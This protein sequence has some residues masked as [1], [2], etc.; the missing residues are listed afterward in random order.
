M[1]MH[2]SVVRRIE[3]LRRAMGAD[4]LAVGRDDGVM[5]F[6]AADLE[7]L[8][9]LPGV[10]SVAGAT[11]SG[12]ASGLGKPYALTYAEVTR[13]YLEAFGV[14]LALGPGFSAAPGPEA[15]L[16]AN[17]A[18]ALFPNQDPIGQIVDGLTVVGVITEIP[19]W[20]N[21]R[22]DLNGKILVPDG[23][24]PA[25]VY[26]ASGQYSPAI[27]RATGDAAAVRREIETRFPNWSIYDAGLAATI[28]NSV[29]LR[30]TRAS[31][32]AGLALVVLV[33][34]G[35]AASMTLTVLRRM[36]E[37][38]IRRAVGAGRG[39]IA[40]DVVAEAA[41]I[42]FAGG[43]VGTAVAAALSPVLGRLPVWM[44][45]A[46][47]TYGLAVGA[48][49]A[50]IPAL[51]ASRMRPVSALAERSLVASGGRR[52]NPSWWVT[53]AATC[54]AACGAGL[55]I[56][57]AVAI[58][59]EIDAAW[60]AADDRILVVGTEPLV[61]YLRGPSSVLP[62]AELRR[63]DARL[64][65]PLGEVDAVVCAMQSSVKLVT[66]MGKL[67]TWATFVDR[68]FAELRLLNILEGRGLNEDDIGSR[69]P[70]CL[71]GEATAR[72][73]WGNARDAIGG[74]ITILPQSAYR[75]VGVFE[76]EY[77]VDP[78]SRGL[79]A[80]VQ[81]DDRM[82]L[83]R[84]RFIVRMHDRRDV[85][86]ARSEIAAAFVGAYPHNAP[87]RV[88]PLMGE[89]ARILRSV[90]A[91]ARGVTPSLLA[92]V[93]VA[94]WVA[95]SVAGFRL[96]ART[97]EFGVR[98]ALGL[99]RF[100]AWHFG[101]REAITLTCI[102]AALGC[103]VAGLCERSV[104]QWVLQGAEA[105]T[106]PVTLFAVLAGALALAASLGVAVAWRMAVGPVADMLQKGRE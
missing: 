38:G 11:S 25:Y 51:T 75:V 81:P 13:D 95:L 89:N 15:I 3:D 66:Q 74:E 17:V 46:L 71:L 62:P 82:P 86:S 49:A 48:V 10:A 78:I 103:T 21:L 98:R 40:R 39:R 8:R 79:V 31:V 36:R 41:A 57:I 26:I 104:R 45:G 5:F 96:R 87:V 1:A 6:A 99:P 32:V 24:A 84:V 91:V 80:P 19:T 61:G 90:L 102:G 97:L 94:A 54:L 76:D 77:I 18:A 50:L 83:N 105:P 16:G 88:L 53:T 35:V 60:G 72:A 29:A 64:I 28:V 7:T 93:A 100:A 34:V 101:A 69:T 9:G 23:Q 106:D 14:S 70:V 42:C 33:G 56:S 92:G 63:R 67:Q 27:V 22:N 20:D 55:A 47:P 37:I 44:Y 12:S 4:V 73:L 43:L 52:R 85:E 30:A 68:G 58:D 59:R 65:S 2:E